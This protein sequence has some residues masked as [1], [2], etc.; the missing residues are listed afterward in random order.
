MT[1]PSQHQAR[2]FAT[3]AAEQQPSVTH[4]LLAASLAEDRNQ[5]ARWLEK[6]EGLTNIKPA[7]K[8]RL[9]LARA[10]LE[11]SGPH[12]QGALPWF[13]K[14]IALDPDNV[15]A[16]VQSADLYGAFGLDQTGLLLIDRALQRLPH[17]VRLL[18]A[19]AERLRKLGRSTEAAEVERQYANLRFD[20]GAWLGKMVEFVIV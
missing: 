16:T 15:E 2:D 8:I 20:D 9:I 19:K 11:R 6:A 14:A 18:S 10:A 13:R 1:D 7:D 4:F 17:S 5:R 12:P 3:E